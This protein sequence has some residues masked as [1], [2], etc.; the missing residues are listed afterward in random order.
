MCLWFSATLRLPLSFMCINDL[1]CVE[2]IESYINL[3][4]IIVIFY[5][6]PIGAILSTKQKNTVSSMYF[7]S[8]QKMILP[9]CAHKNVLE[10]NDSGFLA[11]TSFKSSFIAVIYRLSYF[12]WAIFFKKGPAHTSC[13][14]QTLHWHGNTQTLPHIRKDK[15]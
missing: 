1:H 4:C 7:F 12:L 8:T 2:F 10:V 9:K 6:F 5:C 3:L 14:I 13:F 15:S 11:I